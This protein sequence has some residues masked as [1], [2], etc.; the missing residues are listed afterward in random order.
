MSGVLTPE[1]TETAS[2]GA[3]PTCE[4]CGYM[5]SWGAASWC[6][7]CGF[8]PKLNHDGAEPVSE[9]DDEGDL[10]NIKLVIPS[11]IWTLLAGEL[12]FVVIGFAVR[13]LL[14]DSEGYLSL[15]SLIQLSFGLLLVGFGHYGALFAAIRLDGNMGFKELVFYPPAVWK[16]ILKNLDTKSHLI[17]NMVWGVSLC[18]LALLILGPVKMDKIKEELAATR[19][20]RQRKKKEF[21]GK[22]IGGMAKASA[23]TQSPQ[24]PGGGPMSMEDS[25]ESF[26]GMATGQVGIDDAVNA[27]GG[28]HRANTGTTVAGINTKAI[29]SVGPGQPG[30]ITSQVAPPEVHNRSVH[31]AWRAQADADRPRHGAATIQ[32][33]PDAP[34]EVSDSG[35]P[36]NEDR[37]DS[38]SPTPNSRHSTTPSQTNPATR[39]PDQTPQH[40]P[41]PTNQGTPCIIFG[42]LGNAKGEVRSVLIASD[43]DVEFPK[44]AGRLAIDDLPEDVAKRLSDELPQLRQRRPLI[45][46]PYNAMWVAPDFSV[47]VDH[48]GWGQSG[49]RNPTVQSWSHTPQRTFQTAN[50]INRSPSLSGS[51]DQ[52][53][54]DVTVDIGQ[55]IIP[56]LEAECQPLVVEAKLMQ[57]RG[58]QVMDVNRILRDTKSQL[59][60]LS[61][62]EAPLHSAA[63]HPHGEAVRVVVSTENLPFRCAA[64][65]EWGATELSSPDD[66]RL[67]EETALLQVLDQGGDGL[68]HRSALVRQSISQTG[69]CPGSMVVPAPVEELHEANPLLDQSTGEQ[70]VVGE[71]GSSGFGPVVLHDMLRLFRDVHDLRD[72]C[73]HPVRQLV[74]RDARQCFGMAE[75]SRLNFIEIVQGVQAHPANVSTHA[76]WIGDIQHRIALRATLHSLIN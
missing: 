48:K 45:N 25:I 5:D 61:V 16:I 23:A 60:G 28:G 65:T 20:E 21:V 15:A 73:L 4:K 14:A 7:R 47:I 51:G 70:A 46:C 26:A 49:L 43:P 75:L 66:Q 72:G 71:A 2:A 13:Y 54:D 50:K 6:P 11:W 39:K 3:K 62:V 57:D 22:V 29:G 76:R 38:A 10:S 9:W 24:A 74:L 42:Y 19:E 64:F 36:T 30:D 53:F 67:V 34:P 44:Y 17:M 63:G 37:Q 58:L 1:S 32:E 40:T 59:V 31:E 55:T 8:C 68:V 33:K 52:V 27:S 56:P 69:R 12:A 18:G 35:T 41:V